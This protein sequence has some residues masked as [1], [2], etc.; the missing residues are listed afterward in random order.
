M[1]ETAH[2]IIF[3]DEL[4]QKWMFECEFCHNALANK[5]SLM[6]HQAKSVKCKRIQ[7]NIH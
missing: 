1:T 4:L 2:K 3:W 7:K 6:R 5:Y